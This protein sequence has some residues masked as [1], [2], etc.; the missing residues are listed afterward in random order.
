MRYGI[1]FGIESPERIAPSVKAGFD[2]IEGGFCSLSRAEDEVFEKFK[3]ELEK[4][5]IKMEAANG[6]LPKDLPVMGDDYNQSRLVEYIE[7]G[8]QRGSQIGLKMVAF[9]SSKARSVPDYI[10]YAEGFR[11]IGEFLKNVVSP[12]A[13]KYGITIVTEP[14]RMDECNIINTVKEGVML[15][16]LA[17]KENIS[18]LADNYHMEGAGDTFDD[19][20]QLKGSIKHGHISNPVSKKGLKRDFPASLDEYD[21]QGY[22]DALKEAGCNRCSIEAQCVDFDSEIATAGKLLKSLK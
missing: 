4:N 3:N 13:E 19:I 18:C 15:S 9:G 21:Y 16:V 2:Y 20:I 7:K 8:M 6:F 11:Q 17:G 5:N 22:V 12:L 1:C 10:T 14:L